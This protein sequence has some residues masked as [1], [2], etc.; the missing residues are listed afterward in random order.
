MHF[1]V[2]VSTSLGRGD[3]LVLIPQV[4]YA[5]IY[6]CSLRSHVDILVEHVGNHLDLGLCCCDLLCGR[7]LGTTA[8]EEEGH[9]VELCG[10]LIWFEEWYM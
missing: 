5:H 9:C 4:S 1:L 7:R 2:Q 3:V 10:W 6:G 8:A